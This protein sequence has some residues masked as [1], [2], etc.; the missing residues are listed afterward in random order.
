M[1]TG[2]SSWCGPFMSPKQVCIVVHF[3]NDYKSE[4][5]VC[6]LRESNPNCKSSGPIGPGSASCCL[7][8]SD[9]LPGKLQPYEACGPFSGP[10]L[11]R[12]HQPGHEQLGACVPLRA[13]KLN[14]SLSEMHAHTGGQTIGDNCVPGNVNFLFFYLR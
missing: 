10:H 5:F 14:D 11:T 9:Q 12:K 13:S 2:G 1:D 7:T 4:I 6:F 8:C 3:C